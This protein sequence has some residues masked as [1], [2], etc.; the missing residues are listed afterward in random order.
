MQPKGV[1]C[2]NETQVSTPNL[3]Y[4]H[5]THC[6]MMGAMTQQD[7]VRLGAELKAARKRMRPR[8]SQDDAAQALGVSRSSI[9]KIENGAADRVTKTSLSA[10][11]RF[12]G[13]TADS[14]DRILRGDPPME[15]EPREGVAPSPSP[16]EQAIGEHVNSLGL[17][18]TVEYELRAGKTL[19]STVINLGP[20]EDDGHI[21]VVLQGRK[22]ASPEQIQRVAARYRKARRHLQSIAADVDEGAGE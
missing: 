20:D 19:E 14:V 8:V 9:Q 13:W 3:T 7:Y 18:P 5:A 21:I 10:Y 4:A 11:V 2:S 12:V 1:L 15:A 16:A 17:S 22:D 6:G